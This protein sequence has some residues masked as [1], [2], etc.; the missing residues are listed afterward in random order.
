M[1]TESTDYPS[2]GRSRTSKPVDGLP[3]APTRRAGAIAT[4]TPAYVSIEQAVGYS[5]LGRSTIYRLINE[6][7]LATHKVYHRVLIKLS[8]LAAVIEDGI[9]TGGTAA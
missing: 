5:G 4:I 2:N 1:D 9:A 3:I 7:R 8:D 6:E